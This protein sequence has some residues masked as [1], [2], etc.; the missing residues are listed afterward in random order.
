MVVLILI[1]LLLLLMVILFILNI[2]KNMVLDNLE[3][4]HIRGVSE[5]IPRFKQSDGSRCGL[6]GGA[7]YAVKTTGWVVCLPGP[8]R[9][10]DDGCIGMKRC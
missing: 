1:Y 2:L 7:D 10:K 9:F 8:G 3:L 5:R 6:F 4:S